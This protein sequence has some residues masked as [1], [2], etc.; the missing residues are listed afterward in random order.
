MPQNRFSN[1][2][3]VGNYYFYGTAYNCGFRWRTCNAFLS[4]S[5]PRV[6]Y[7]NSQLHKSFLRFQ[8]IFLDGLADLER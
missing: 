8:N 3:A 4:V 2:S 7:L 1:T 5:H 6:N